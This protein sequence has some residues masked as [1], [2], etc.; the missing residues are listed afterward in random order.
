MK[1]TKDLKDLTVV[2][3][4]QREED[5]RQEMFNLSMQKIAGQIENPLRLR[6]ARREVA[7]VKTFLNQRRKDA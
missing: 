6:Y 4:Q 7:R 1:K 2:E 5:A 3:L